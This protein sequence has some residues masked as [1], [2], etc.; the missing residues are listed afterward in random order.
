[1]KT[2]PVVEEWSIA[3]ILA[4]RMAK[5]VDLVEKVTNELERASRG[6]DQ[7]FLR[8]TDYQCQIQ[9]GITF[10]DALKTSHLNRYRD[11]IPY[12][13]SM[14][15]LEDPIH[16]GA[17][18]GPS[19]YINASWIRDLKMEDMFRGVGNSDSCGMTYIAAQG[20]IAETCESFWRMMVEKKS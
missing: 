11:V 3:N 10:C 16:Y 13:H 5:S 2:K 20:P 6:S 12:H 15:T 7:S 17:K 19:N 9:T 18:F 8:I 1:M 4:T 14:V